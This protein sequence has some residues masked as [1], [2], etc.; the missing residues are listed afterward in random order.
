MTLEQRV[1]KLEKEM[2]EMKEAV[3]T[4]ETA[5]YSL[6]LGV[7]RNAKISGEVSSSDTP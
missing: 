2:A 3:K 1:E 4:V 5:E 7:V 6:N